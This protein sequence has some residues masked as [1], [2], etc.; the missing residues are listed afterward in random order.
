MPDLI[1]L[2]TEAGIAGDLIKLSPGE[3]RANTDATLFADL[4]SKFPRPH[5]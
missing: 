1:A 5:G 4:K 3:R 2:L